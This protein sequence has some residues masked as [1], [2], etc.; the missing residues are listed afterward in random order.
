MFGNLLTETDLQTELITHEKGVILCSVEFVMSLIEEL[1]AE[2]IAIKMAFVEVYNER[3][4][5]LL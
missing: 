4:N 2:A 1:K 3:L 5:D